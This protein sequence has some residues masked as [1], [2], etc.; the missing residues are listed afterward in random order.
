MCYNIM[1]NFPSDY[2][3]PRIH[4][5]PV[6]RIAYTA[7]LSDYGVADWSDPN[8]RDNSGEPIIVIRTGPSAG[9]AL[10][11]GTHRVTY[12]ARDSAGNTAYPCSFTV[13]VRR[14]W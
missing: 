1:D 6:N 5:C 2:E 14:T 11:V 4:N 10:A 12:N 9:T 7:K 3:R 13:N 8:V